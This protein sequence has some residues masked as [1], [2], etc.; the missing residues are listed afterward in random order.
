MI[1]NSIAAA[2]IALAAQGGRAG[3]AETLE[4]AFREAHYMVDV[5]ARYESVEQADIAAAADALTSRLRAGLETAPLHRTSLLMEG[6]WIEDLVDE[7]NS[8]TNGHTEF[9]VVA[10]PADFAAI[11]RF[12]LINKSLESTTLT[13]GRQRIVL[14]DSRFVGNVGWRQHEQ[15]F[16]GLRAQVAKTA[17]KADLTYAN[18]VNRVFGPD[19]PQGKWEGDFALLNVARTL[20]FGTLTVFDYLVDTGD[21]VAMSSNT[22]G[23]RLTGSKPLGSISS[24]YAVAYARQSDA[25]EN[26][27]SYDESY[28]FVEGGL[29]FAKVGVG[30]GYE[31]LGGNGVAAF[32]TPLATLHVFQGWADKF[33]ATPAAGIE[34]RYV[35]ASYAFGKRGRFTSVSAAGFFHDFV[36]DAGSVPFGEELDLQLVA[37]TERVALTLKYSDYR[38]QSLH[39][40]TT[41]LWLSVDY[42]F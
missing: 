37:R 6:V 13:L 22:L 31:V 4:Q 17:F 30:L 7:Y 32:N 34:D 25:G 10:D 40:D 41:K 3:A 26:P 8:T 39:T 20:P 21:A 16:D 14:D 28:R 18:Q 38:A 36:S 9:P 5:R 35:R 24:T 42:A 15:T 19:S 11:N 27:T 33:L 1:R 2:C 12:A 23:A 29:A